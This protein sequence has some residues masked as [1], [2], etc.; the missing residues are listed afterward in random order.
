M[1]KLAVELP[2]KLA[3]E[4]RRYVADGWFASEEELMRVALR[5]FLR[6]N[7]TDLLER[8]HREDI[9]WALSQTSQAKAKP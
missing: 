7:R 9:A 1:T 2:D 4:V 8:F 6:R 5:D 3:D